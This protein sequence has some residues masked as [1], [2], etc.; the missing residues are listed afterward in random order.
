MKKQL[1]SF[2]FSALFLSAGIF[3]TG[4]SK[5]EDKTNGDLT[6]NAGALV[7]NEGQFQKGNGGVSFISQ[8]NNEVTRDVFM[9]VNNRPLGD[10]VQSLT[11][12]DGKIYVV[13]N[14]SEKIEI[15]DARTFKEAGVING[16][17]LP[18]YAVASEDKLYV[19]EWVNYGLSGRVAVIDLDSNT[20][21]KTITVGQLPEKVLLLN[22]KLHVLNNGQN[23]IS[24]INTTTDAV[25]TTI[26]VGDSPNGIV[27]TSDGIWVLCGGKK[28][29]GGAPDYA[30]D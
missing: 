12:H 21:S 7:T 23:T 26:Q 4:C 15:A 18:R 22:K 9:T 2:A 30:L 3:F 17:Q 24:V 25:E 13:V 6:F 14:N 8:Q 10:V 28:V 11:E 5:E 16:L 1:T 20:V 19:T 29:Y 27:T